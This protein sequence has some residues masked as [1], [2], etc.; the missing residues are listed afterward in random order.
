MIR[1]SLLI[2]L[3]FAGT[4][5]SQQAKKAKAADTLPFSW[6]SPLQNAEWAKKILPPTAKHATF[7]SPSMGIDVGYYIY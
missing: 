7:K 5:F 3:T 6:V 4:I 2:L 1:L